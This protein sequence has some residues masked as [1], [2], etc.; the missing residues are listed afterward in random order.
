[1]RA[2]LK[3]AKKN[4]ESQGV[5][6]ISAAGGAAA[7]GAAGWKAKDYLSDSGGT[8]MN[9]VELDTPSDTP[10]GASKT[11]ETLSSASPDT[12]AVDAQPLGK[13]SATPVE[14]AFD[15]TGGT[16]IDTP[17]MDDI[18]GSGGASSTGLIDD[19]VDTAKTTVKSV[20]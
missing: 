6:P 9:T 5:D 10:D 11:T 17:D 4:N 8:S 18:G 15:S 16:N 2:L 1:M 14:D 3:H 20:L 19:A 12:D 7:G 13:G